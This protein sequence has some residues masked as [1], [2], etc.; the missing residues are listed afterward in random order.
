LNVL[1][2][3]EP[4]LR[5]DSVR[6]G[7]AMVAYNLTKTLENQ[8]TVTYFPSIV[9][10]PRCYAVNLLKV[11]RRFASREFEIIHFNFNPVWH[12]GSSMLLRLAKMT[13]TTTLLNIHGIIQVEYILDSPRTRK[14]RSAMEKALMN[15]L[16]SCKRVDQVVTYSEFMRNQIVTWYG[17]NREKI[18]VIPNGVNLKKFSDYTGKLLLEGDPAILYV[19]YLSKF[20]SVD[21]LICAI[22]KL[23]SEL[24]NM[25]LH[26]V[27]HGNQRGLELL[28]KKKQ[29][30]KIV[31]FHGQANPE[32][33]PLYYRS[34][35]FC[36]FPSIRDSAGLT[37]LEAMASGTPVI[38]SNRG[39]TPEII[40]QGENGILFEPD[41]DNAL[42]EAMLSLSQDT[43][44]NKKLSSNALKTVANYSWEKIGEKYISLYKSLCE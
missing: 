17:V 40:T 16:R 1:Y 20:K 36:V 7:V 3:M 32:A 11:Y 26:I 4:E 27:G 8:A 5:V 21:L 18:A 23:R 10:S 39:G 9:V 2:Y 28:A 38:A 33:T 24:P 19:G 15:T 34:A 29:V 42:P 31:V 44:L 12:N 43:D 14:F 6:G 22:S 35:D 37:L 41:D 25:K 30:E 13:G